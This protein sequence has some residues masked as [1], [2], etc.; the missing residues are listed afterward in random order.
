M[1][2]WLGFTSDIVWDSKLWAGGNSY[3]MRSLWLICILLFCL[4]LGL[5]FRIISE[6][7]SDK[8]LHQICGTDGQDWGGKADWAFTMIMAGSALLW[9]QTR[10]EPSSDALNHQRLFR[11]QLTLLTG[12]S[13]PGNKETFVIYLELFWMTTILFL[14]CYSVNRAE[15]D[16][17]EA[18]NDLWVTFNPCSYLSC[19]LVETFCFSTAHRASNLKVLK[20]YCRILCRIED[21]NLC[22]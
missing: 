15:R 9:V 11:L 12:L 3:D 6:G 10:R 16:T 14:W 8:G 5:G 2:L 20:T 1:C 18:L 13:C 22:I 21:Q 7:R 4:W 19:P 17:E